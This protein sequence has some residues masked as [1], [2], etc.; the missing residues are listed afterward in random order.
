MQAFHHKCSKHH[1]DSEIAEKI[2]LLRDGT[3]YSLGIATSK[4][5]LNPRLHVFN[6]VGIE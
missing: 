1:L 2:N 4:K 3:M 5:F 6:K